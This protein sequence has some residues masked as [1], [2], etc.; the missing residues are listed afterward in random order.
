MNTTKHNLFSSLANG[1]ELR[2]LDGNLLL[3]NVQGVEL[4][5][6][7]RKCWNVEGYKEGNAKTIFVR[8]VD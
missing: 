6:G 2:D 3:T 4:E 1:T 5:S 7:G 8:T